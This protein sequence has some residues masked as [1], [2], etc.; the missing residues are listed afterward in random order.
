VRGRGE[1]IGQHSC[2]AHIV[3]CLLAAMV[4]RAARARTGALTIDWI[5]TEAD[6]QAGQEATILKAVFV[7]SIAAR[8]PGRP[9][10]SWPMLTCS[11]RSLHDGPEVRVLRDRR[12]V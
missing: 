1:H 2:E 3:C 12:L 4:G 10:S 11:S 7:H 8:V 9:D 6:R 5:D